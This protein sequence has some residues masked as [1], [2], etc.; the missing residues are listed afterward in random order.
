LT[1]GGWT[2]TIWPRSLARQP[3]TPDLEPV[4]LVRAYPARP[5]PL[6]PFE[7]AFLANATRFGAAGWTGL[8]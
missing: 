1:G 8:S 6:K 3:P 5:D 7:M 2:F 4:R